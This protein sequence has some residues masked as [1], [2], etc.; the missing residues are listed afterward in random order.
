MVKLNLTTS[1]R[2]HATVS[3]PSVIFL[4]AMQVVFFV[5]DRLNDLSCNV[6]VQFRKFL[7]PYLNETLSNFSISQKET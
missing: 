1:S 4:A 3:V 7:L 6:S 5:F 2:C